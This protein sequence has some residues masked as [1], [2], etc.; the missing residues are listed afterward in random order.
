MPGGLEAKIN[1][2]FVSPIPYFLHSSGI[3]VCPTD[4]PSFTFYSIYAQAN[5]IVFITCA[6]GFH[7]PISNPV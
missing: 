5:A 7:F 4:L 2:G 6:S 3:S 1:E